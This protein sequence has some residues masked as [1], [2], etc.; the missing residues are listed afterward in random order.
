MIFGM[1]TISENV[2]LLS[3]WVICGTIAINKSI[4]ILPYTETLYRQSVTYVWSAQVLPEVK[5]VSNYN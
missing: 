3:S 1:I 5:D 2:I 4:I